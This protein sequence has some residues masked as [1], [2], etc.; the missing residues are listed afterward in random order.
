VKLVGQM[1]VARVPKGIL[2]RH[3]D[4]KISM[5]VNLGESMCVQLTCAVRISQVAIHANVHPVPLQML[6]V[7]VLLQ[8]NAK[9]IRNAL[10]N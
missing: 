8:M 10:T 3:P 7:V 1:E 5:S 6:Y 4:V 2:R 9:G